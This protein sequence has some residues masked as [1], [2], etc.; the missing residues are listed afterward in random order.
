MKGLLLYILLKGL[1]PYNGII[2][3]ATGFT[4]KMKW[5]EKTEVVEIILGYQVQVFLPPP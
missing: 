4:A 3:I 5:V 2:V 1:H